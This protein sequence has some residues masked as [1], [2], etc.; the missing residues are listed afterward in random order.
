MNSRSEIGFDK[1]GLDEGMN[2]ML[3]KSATFT[4]LDEK[5][6][7]SKQSISV[8]DDVHLKSVYGRFLVCLSNR[9]VDNS[10]ETPKIETGWNIMKSDT[11]YIPAWVYQRPTFSKFLNLNI[12]VDSMYGR[13]KKQ[14]LGSLPANVQEMR[15]IEDILDVMLGFDGEYI[16]K[17]SSNQF[18]IEPQKDRPTCSLA[19]AELASKILALPTAYNIIEN[20]ISTY[21]IQQGT[22]CQALCSGLR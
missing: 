3:E 19:L 11:P 13:E 1:P 8:Y 21:S 16:K 12:E 2:N 6:V 10:S 7:R 4:L 14:S 18:M 5:N 15:I 17:N 20:Y 9:K 22:V